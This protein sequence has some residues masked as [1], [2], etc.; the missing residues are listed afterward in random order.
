MYIYLVKLNLTR[1]QLFWPPCDS[2]LSFDLKDTAR[3]WFFTLP[4]DVTSSL[5]NLKSAFLNRFRQPNFSFG[6]VDI[7]QKDSESIEQ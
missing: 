3:D 6:L 7:I 5:E 1:V 4:P 2:F